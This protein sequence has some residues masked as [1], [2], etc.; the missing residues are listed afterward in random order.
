[1]V[2][3]DTIVCRCEDVTY[4]QI[5]DLIARGITHPDDIKRILRCGMG[6]CQG[7]TCQ[8]LVR[9]ILADCI[10]KGQAGSVEIRDCDRWTA[11]PPLR[12]VELGILAGRTDGDDS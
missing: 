9:R 7:R 1:M 5:K 12:P 8:E 11:R 3:E 6:P 10:G 2:D 4:G